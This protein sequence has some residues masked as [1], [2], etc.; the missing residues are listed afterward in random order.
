MG[1]RSY[2]PLYCASAKE[3]M[4]LA[5]LLIPGDQLKSR[6]RSARHSS[7]VQHMVILRQACALQVG[8]PPGWGYS[9]TSPMVA[10]GRGTWDFS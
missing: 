10:E 7:L 5:H 2:D 9:R 8:G 6:P 4:G 1:G 3:N